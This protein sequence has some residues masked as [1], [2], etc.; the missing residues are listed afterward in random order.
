MNI[1]PIRYIINF[2]LHRRMLQ[3]EHACNFDALCNIFAAMCRAF[4]CQYTEFRCWV[5]RYT[6]NGKCPVPYFGDITPETWRNAILSESWYYN[7][8]WIR[9]MLQQL[10]ERKKHTRQR[11]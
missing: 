7:E 3:S 10:H 2:E 9:K 6:L 4:P 5:C 1:Q 8:K 11:T